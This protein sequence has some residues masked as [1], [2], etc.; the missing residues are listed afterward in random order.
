MAT[1][2]MIGRAMRRALQWRLLVVSAVLLGV[3]D[4]LTTSP[5]GKGRS[6]D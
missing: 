5:H 3:L 4:R 6:D 2:S 1:L